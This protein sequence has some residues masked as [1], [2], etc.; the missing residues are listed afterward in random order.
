MMPV[1]F[2]FLVV[3]R[4][5]SPG[6]NSLGNSD[7]KDIKEHLTLSDKSLVALYNNLTKGSC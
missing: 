3:F 4:T 5:G 7:I 2:L 6:K 1:G